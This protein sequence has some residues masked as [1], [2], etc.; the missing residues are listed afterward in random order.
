M[1]NNVISITDR[2]IDKCFKDY[3]DKVRDHDMSKCDI[4]AMPESA[5]IISYEKF[6][7]VRAAKQRSMFAAKFGEE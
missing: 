1:E 5:E 4:Y 7:A 3:A 2:L 6:K